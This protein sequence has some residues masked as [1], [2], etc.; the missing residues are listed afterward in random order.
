MNE[1]TNNKIA[2]IRI[3]VKIRKFVVKKIMKHTKI[4]ATIGPAS[5]DKQMLTKMIKAGLNVARLN[6]SHG[7]YSAHFKYIKNI[8]SVAKAAGANVAILQD[9]QGPRIRIGKLSQSGIRV[10]RN[11]KV[12]L[13]PEALPRPKIHAE[14]IPVQY[15]RLSRD[16]KKGAR[17]LID[18][19]T[20]ELKV[21]RI[22][23]NLIYCHVIT[24]GIIRS[25]KGL[26]FPASCLS[27]PLITRKDVADLEF[28][29]KNNVDFI[30]M[31]F[32]KS[33]REIVEMRKKIFA[34]E[35]KF[36]HKSLERKFAK[37]PAKG[38]VS[39]A[40]IRIIAK[41]ERQEAVNN[42]DKIL[43]AADGIMVARGDLGIEL[44]FEKLPLIQKTIIEKCRKA[45][46]PVI[47][48]TQM[49]DS[50]I[51]NPLPTRAEVSDVANAILDSTDAIMLSG[52]SATGKYPLQAVQAMNR[53]SLQ[54]EGREIA[55]AEESEDHYRSQKSITQIISYIA[56]DLA[57]DVTGA[58]LI[59][60]ATTSG[61][62][63]KNI[64]SFRPGLPIIAVTPSEL[65][66][67]QL[68]LSWGVT[69]H[70]LPF[71]QSFTTLLSG[72]KNMLLEHKLVKRK[73]IVV[74][75]AGHP[76]GYRGQANLIKVEI[77]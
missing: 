12:I 8:R 40:H 34:L 21:D 47:V 22:K 57:E 11:E 24:P 71:T 52:E 1:Y 17:V 6:F 62:T 66:L 44:P 46:K 54:M 37:P 29:V 51:R 76:F 69:A 31:S 28:G 60:C 20:I 77:I 35:K 55:E 72:I 56:H 25:H 32:V 13:Y 14:L 33:A 73:Q 41:I 70:L 58:K 42:F 61:F 3:L 10:V 75:V 39:G 67:R 74:V 19:A 27:C 49:L 30:A 38:K 5:A 68:A 59:V 64:S 26:N 45:G 23:N 63:A 65:T 48:A 53:I 15:P 16:L 9:L 7:E 36:G 43:E 4:V 18:D 50:M 2:L